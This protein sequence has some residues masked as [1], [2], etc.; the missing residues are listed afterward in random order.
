MA[1]QTQREGPWES[2]LGLEPEWDGAFGQFWCH[3]LSDLTFAGSFIHER[4]VCHVKLIGTNFTPEEITEI[5]IFF[6][7]NKTILWN[8]SIRRSSEKFLDQVSVCATIMSFD[9]PSSR[10]SSVSLTEVKLLVQWLICGQHIESLEDAKWDD[11]YLKF[12]LLPFVVPLLEIEEHLGSPQNWLQKYEESFE[13]FS[14]Q[15]GFNTGAFVDSNDGVVEVIFSAEYV[16]G[17]SYSI[18]HGRSIMASSTVSIKLKFPTSLPIL[19]EESSESEF[20]PQ[21]LASWIRWLSYL[22]EII[23]HAPSS[24]IEIYPKSGRDRFRLYLPFNISKTPNSNPKLTY[25]INLTND[26]NAWD[27]LIKKWFSLWDIRMH[28]ADAIRYISQSLRHDKGNSSIDEFLLSAE[29]TLQ[30]R[31]GAE[32]GRRQGDT[33][34]KIIKKSIQKSG[35]LSRIGDSI[36]EY[37]TYTAENIALVTANLCHELIHPGTKGERWNLRNHLRTRSYQGVYQISWLLLNTSLAM[38]I[39]EEIKDFIIPHKACMHPL[40]RENSGDIDWLFNGWNELY[41]ACNKDKILENQK[42]NRKSMLEET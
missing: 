6:Q 4:G 33:L 19:S 3:E 25:A 5:I 7:D 22:F 31:W 36:N 35:I 1:G 38:L 29:R 21:N 40:V 32:K 41:E 27:G 30:A 24:E 16:G 15:E 10:S 34:E 13:S 14:K 42:K 23:F 9:H 26:E 17:P 28:W 39:D 12:D 20:F 18:Y 37:P 8:G 11:I 2:N